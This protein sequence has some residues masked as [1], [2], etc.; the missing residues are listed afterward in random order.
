MVAVVG[1]SQANV[2]RQILATIRRTSIHQ[3]RS[4]LEMA[5]ITGCCNELI[6][7]FGYVRMALT[8][9]DV[10]IPNEI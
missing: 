2:A 10:P 4:I 9:D 3:S 1:W 7:I 5:T 6:A 8:T